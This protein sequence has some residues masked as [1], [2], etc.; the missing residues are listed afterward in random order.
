M[1]KEPYAQAFPHSDAILAL[2]ARQNVNLRFTSRHR[3]EHA[4]SICGSKLID[5]AYSL[6]ELGLRK[7]YIIRVRFDHYSIFSRI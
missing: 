4:T 1:I 3:A 6:S 5:V 7:V 2:N